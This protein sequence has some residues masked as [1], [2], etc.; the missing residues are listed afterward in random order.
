VTQFNDLVAKSNVLVN[1]DP[2]EIV[3]LPLAPCNV[4][5]AGNWQ[6]I[7]ALF[8]PLVGNGFSVQQVANMQIVNQL[9]QKM[10]V[11]P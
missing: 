11:M 2:D 1:A 6:A 5:Q 7:E 10:S 8:Q 3:L 4:Q 9:A